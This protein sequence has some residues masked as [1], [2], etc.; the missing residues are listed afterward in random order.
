MDVI[1]VTPKGRLLSYVTRLLWNFDTNL[2]LDSWVLISW[3]C[4]ALQ[5]V[6]YS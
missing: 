2:Y 5:T 4:S 3:R 6:K 1:K